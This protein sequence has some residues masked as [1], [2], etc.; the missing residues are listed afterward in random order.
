MLI[1]REVVEAAKEGGWNP[2]DEPYE[3]ERVDVGTA[4]RV[5]DRRPK[6]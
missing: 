2:F 6:G 5:F 4:R 1:P 3:I